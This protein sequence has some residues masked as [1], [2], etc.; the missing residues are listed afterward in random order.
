MQTEADCLS[1]EAQKLVRQ[2]GGEGGRER[3]G[4][5]AAQGSPAAPAPKS[6]WGRGGTCTRSA[7]PGLLS[8]QSAPLMLVCVYTEHA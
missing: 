3:E 4:C 5:C 6:Q 1:P 7:L 2:T 8:L